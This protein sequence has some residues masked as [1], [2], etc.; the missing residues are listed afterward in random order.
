[1]WSHRTDINVALN[2]INYSHPT[3]KSFPVSTRKSLST[4]PR[5]T[6]AKDWITFFNTTTK[7]LPEIILLIKIKNPFP[8]P[9]K[10]HVD[11]I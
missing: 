6:T 2:T 11:Q 8:E 7:R 4:H 3:R 10:N 5:S 9:K 1:L